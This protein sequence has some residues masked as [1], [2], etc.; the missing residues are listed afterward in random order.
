M[1]ERMSIG[2]L[3]LGLYYGSSLI[4]L[5]EYRHRCHIRVLDFTLLK[6]WKHT[7]FTS[8]LISLDLYLTS[9]KYLESRSASLVSVL[10]VGLILVHTTMLTWKR[11]CRSRE[12]R[13]LNMHE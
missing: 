1:H 3:H 13:G 11:C 7:L 5:H 4:Q 6:D 2:D 10:F 12:D 8:F 9:S